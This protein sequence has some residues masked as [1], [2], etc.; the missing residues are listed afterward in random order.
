MTNGR[1]PESCAKVTSLLM[2]RAAGV[3]QV[4]M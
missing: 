1:Q 4:T 2:S 3:A